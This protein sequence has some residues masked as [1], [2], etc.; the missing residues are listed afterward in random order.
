TNKIGVCV[1]RG[2]IAFPLGEEPADPSA[3][4]VTY[5]YGFSANMG[6]GP[7]DRRDEPQR[8][9]Q[10][11]RVRP[12]TVQHPNAFGRL[13]RIPADAPTITAAVALWNPAVDPQAVIQIEDQRTYTENVALN[14]PGGELIL[15]AANQLR[16]TLLGNV[17]VTAAGGEGRMRLDGL[18]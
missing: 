4:Q 18:W 13:I 5:D 17:T 12:D 3:V 9:G 6:G 14:I 11:A 1:H 16:P 7:Y 2:R 10:P 8:L 15:Q